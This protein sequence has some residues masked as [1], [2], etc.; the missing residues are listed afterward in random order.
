MLAAFAAV[1]TWA[2]E[3]PS[4]RLDQQFFVVPPNARA[5]RELASFRQRHGR[6]ELLWSRDTLLPARIL[7]LESRLAPALTTA[8]VDQV[9]GEFMTANRALL[10]VS[11]EDLVRRSLVE[12]RGRILVKYQQTFQGVPIDGSE[13][14]FITTRDGR[15]LR[16]ASSYAP[17]ADV[18]TRGNITEQRAVEL[19]RRAL[20]NLGANAVLDGA[21]LVL[22]RRFVQGEPRYRLVYEVAMDTRVIDQCP[23]RLVVID[24]N[25]GEVVA[26]GD[27]FP[28]RIRGTVRGEIYPGRSTDTP[29]LRPLGHLSV[30]ASRPGDRSTQLVPSLSDGSYSLMAGTGSWDVRAGLSGSFAQVTSVSATN[31]R[32]EASVPDGSTHDWDWSGSSGDDLEQINVFYHINRIHDFYA[33][34]LDHEW[35]NN[36]TGTRQFRAETGY[37]TDN[38]WSGDPLK[39][40]A[41]EYSL[42]AGVIYHECTHNVLYDLFGDEW[43]GYVSG[44]DTANQ[45]EAYAFDEGF[46][47]FFACALLGWSDHG[48]R[49]LE[50]EMEYPDEYDE[51]TGQGLEGHDGGQIIGGAAWELRLLMQ[52]RLGPERG[53]EES[54][55]LVFD[56]LATLATFPRPY[57]F[58]YPG[59]SNLLDALLIADDNDDFAIDGTPNDREILQ[60][61]RHHRMLPVD[62]WVRDHPTEVYGVPSNPGGEPFWTSP[63]IFLYDGA[64]LLEPDAILETGVPVEIQV[65]VHNHGYLMAE[66]VTV[67]VYSA[68]ASE[69]LSWP[70]DWTLIGTSVVREIR[71][72]RP[73]L[74]PRLTWRPHTPGERAL[75]VRLVC[76]DDPI[77]DPDDVAGDNNVAQR[78]VSVSAFLPDSN[79]GIYWRVVPDDRFSSTRRAME[80]LTERFPPELELEVEWLDP[81]TR[82]R[83]ARSPSAARYTAHLA[84]VELSL[85]RSAAV[86]PEARAPEAHVPEITPPTSPP[87][88]DRIKAESDEA[89]S[90]LDEALAGLQKRKTAEKA[91]KAAKAEKSVRAQAKG[92]RKPAETPGDRPSV[93]VLSFPLE[94]L[95]GQEVLVKV[96]FRVPRTARPGDAYV[97]HLVDRAGDRVVSGM[98]YVVRVRG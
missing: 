80:I 4:T 95:A 27:R 66:E 90:K 47:D 31:I 98:T 79:A 58:S 35:I 42:D 65:R 44:D 11:A 34:S 62:V 15:L 14:G 6:A 22:R 86:A 63:D 83:L 24:A 64:A 40:G 9:L 38:A 53:A 12:R 43:I 85:D 69:G 78:N 67:E 93:D 1:L 77:T 39:F 92:A 20:G 82:N 10:G 13:V 46:A 5:A 2:Q 21:E 61:F 71:A 18:S 33:S 88:R 54:T 37:A 45:H 74:S 28:S 87:A 55:A 25:T 96:S 32:H 7:A 81:R 60:A 36:W 17:V 19:A 48:D 49:D 3:R 84:P 68:D 50:N 76:E 94:S 97:L 8:T 16:Y 30:L 23:S 29:E 26:V 59:T 57:R 89:L 41:D 70:R 52:E 73:E 91:A 51:E 56:A 72:G 75:M